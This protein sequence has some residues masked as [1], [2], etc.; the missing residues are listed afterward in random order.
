MKKR[1]P[2]GPELASAQE[3]NEFLLS[4]LNATLEQAIKSTVSI[5]VKAEMTQLREQLGYP[6][7]MS[8]NGSYPRHLISP[9]GKVENIPIPR[10][11]EGA[12]G[13]E[14]TALQIFGSEQERFHELV[15]QL[16]LAGI[17]QRKINTFCQ[18]VFGK[19]VA[20]KTTKLVFEELLQEEAFQINKTDLT[21]AP[22][23]I[24]Y[25]D[26]I[27]QKVKNSLTG[28]IEERVVIAALGM[29]EAGNKQLLGFVVTHAED[30][31]GAGELLASLQKRGINLDAVK[32]FVTDESKGILAALARTIAEPPIQLCLVH[33]YRNVLKY[34]PLR[35]RGA[36][37]KD[38]RQL[39]QASSPTE[40]MS[41]MK[42]MQKRWQTIAPRAIKRL[43][44]NPELLTTYFR[45]DA[46]LWPKIRTTN[47][48]ERTFREVRS[49]TR[50][51]QHQF[52]SRQSA[53]KYH[54]TIFG[55]LN[56]QYFKQGGAM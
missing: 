38:L 21:N 56:Q 2:S 45:F 51:N 46:A 18:Q 23:N 14:L 9:A 19:A 15:R 48:L 44:R 20:P 3:L 29:S 17:S 37:G 41:Q 47:T 55:N 52:A 27:W 43:V 54:N 49:R 34:T 36:M 28:E 50:V 33:R 39:T 11:R 40:F 35:Q 7:G 22:A 24:I 1:T 25:L 6:P 12:Q 4:N 32:L 8:F 42:E 26:G 53:E 10:F 30:A 13:I 16:H 31:K 5:T